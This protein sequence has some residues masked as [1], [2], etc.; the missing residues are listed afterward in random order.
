MFQ[1]EG[2]LRKWNK[3]DIVAKDAAGNAGD[4]V[5][6]HLLSLHSRNAL[7]C[8]F[9]MATWSRSRSETAAVILQH[10]F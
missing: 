2:A 8:K 5:K 10:Q 4:L 7:A 3:H 6:S 9:N 1:Y